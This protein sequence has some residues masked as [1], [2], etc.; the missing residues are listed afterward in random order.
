MRCRFCIY[1]IVHFAWIFRSNDIS[2][3]FFLWNVFSSFWITIVPS[4]CFVYWTFLCLFSLS[5]WLIFLR[6]FSI[7]CD[8]WFLRHFWPC[9][10]QHWKDLSIFCLNQCQQGT[11]QEDWEWQTAYIFFWEQL[12]WLIFANWWT[13]DTTSV[14]QFWAIVW[15]QRWVIDGVDRQRG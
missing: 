6:E 14:W 7:S 13:A 11:W 10:L 12:W 15:D 9:L 5:W 3:G 1:V 4:L 2:L 8:H